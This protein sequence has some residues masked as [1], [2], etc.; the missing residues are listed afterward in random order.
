MYRRSFLSLAAAALRKTPQ[1][2][3]ADPHRPKYHLL[4]PANWMNDPN[5][6]IYWRGR[7]HMFYQYNPHGAFWGTM[8]WGHAI[9][10][11]MI[12]WRHLPP[13]FAPQPGS[14]DKDG[15]FSG[16]AVV[17]NGVPT[18]V[19]TG[20]Q[21][22]VQCIAT[23][24]DDNLRSWRRPAD[25]PVITNP[26]E[27]MKVTGFRD[28]CVWQEEGSWYMALGSG[29]KDVGGMVLLYHSPDLVNWTYLH[30][31]F[32][33][34]MD[35]SAKGRGPVAT[36][37]MWECPSF[38]PLGAKHVLFVSTR[39][40][41]PYWIGTF[42]N[43]KTF[44]PDV[45]GRLDTGAYYAPITQV[46]AQGRRILWG[47][48]QEQRDG[49]SQR[50]AGWSGVMSLPRVLSIRTDGVLGI[51]P[52]PQTRI[53]RGAR[54]QFVNLFVPEGEPEPVPDLEGD[55]LELIAVI[56]S[57]ADEYG[58]QVL[59]TSVLFSAARD[60]LRIGAARLEDTGN[61]KLATNESL[62]LHIFVDC[63]VIEVFANGRCCVTGRSYPPPG[64]RLP[65]S[66]LAR[67][68]TAKLRSLT[69]FD[70][71]PISPDRLTT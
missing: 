13:A 36:G 25:N 6:P 42:S 17:N 44:T 67:G 30:P 23:S 65:V 27:G 37:E 12:H 26:P 40:T 68:G 70:M 1:Q 48:I 32:E 2:L 59:G 16:C 10:T 45:Q 14:Y 18:V 58:I 41:T 34:K 38:F 66:L 11:D 31:L 60:R 56:D 5:G 8:H 22:E 57:D 35:A 51:D 55:A 39:D 62:R 54:R 46:D 19:Y 7:Y 52:A 43:E 29:V 47:W 9:S 4:P 15:V 24:H 63:S 20:T 69:V 49:T 21:P 71:K 33:G 53:L 64:E 61:L 50:A 28:P 3:A